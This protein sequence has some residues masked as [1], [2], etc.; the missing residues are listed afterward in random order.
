MAVCAGM[1]PSAWDIFSGGDVADND[2]STSV[3]SKFARGTGGRDAPLISPANLRSCTPRGVVSRTTSCSARRSLGTDEDRPLGG[4]SGAR[5]VVGTTA[6]A[7]PL[8]SG[9]GVRHTSRGAVPVDRRRWTVSASASIRRSSVTF[10]SA[11]SAR[12]ASTASRLARSAPAISRCNS[13]M[14]ARSASTRSIPSLSCRR[15]RATCVESS[16]LNWRAAC[17]AE[18]SAARRWSWDSNPHIAEMHSRAWVSEDVKCVRAW[19]SSRSTK[20][21]STYNRSSRSWRYMAAATFSDAGTPPTAIGG[22]EATTG[23][24]DACT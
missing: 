18:C 14:A 8:C 2:L 23:A 9:E 22:S 15:I 17:S 21:L 4:S 19:C 6:S 3:V 11:H 5:Y 24:C 7:V 12:S 10:S 16:S 20:S 13:A 1:R